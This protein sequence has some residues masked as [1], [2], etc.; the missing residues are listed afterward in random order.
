MIHKVE[1]HFHHVWMLVLRPKIQIW[2]PLAFNLAVWVLI[3]SAHE[4]EIECRNPPYPFTQ[5]EATP[6]CIGAKSP[7]APPPRSLFAPPPP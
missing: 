5:F 7:R 6:L 3:E 4:N 2:Y 1:L